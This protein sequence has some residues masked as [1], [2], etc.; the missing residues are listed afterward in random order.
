MVYPQKMDIINKIYAMPVAKT[1]LTKMRETEKSPTWK[2]I[3]F[4]VWLCYTECAIR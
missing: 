2:L 3:D 1:Q 4:A